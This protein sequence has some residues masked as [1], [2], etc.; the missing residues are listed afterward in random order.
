[1]TIKSANYLVLVGGDYTEA[2]TTNAF[3]SA[4]VRSISIGH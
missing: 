1:M 2:I 3:V 4:L